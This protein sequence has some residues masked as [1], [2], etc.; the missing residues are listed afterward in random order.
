MVVEDMVVEDM[1]VE[2]DMAGKYLCV[3]LSSSLS[4]LYPV[5]AL[6]L[7]LFSFL[8]IVNTNQEMM[9]QHTVGG[10]SSR[11]KTT[12]LLLCLFCNPT[13]GTTMIILY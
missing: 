6:S 13:S 5:F 11:D 2:A 12:M 9:H 7:T 3:L 10:K 8:V 1:A 4:L